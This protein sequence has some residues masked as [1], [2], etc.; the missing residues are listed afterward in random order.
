MLEFLHSL[1]RIEPVIDCYGAPLKYQATYKGRL[2]GTKH[3]IWDYQ[4][5]ITAFVTEGA[6]LY[7]AAA[8]R[9]GIEV[10]GVYYEG[11]GSDRTAQAAARA[12]YAAHP[13][14]QDAAIAH[15]DDDIAG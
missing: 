9:D 7:V 13:E 3:Y 11:N 6:A 15:D 5:G 4:F 12:Y 2:S 10:D 14:A 8:M 1:G